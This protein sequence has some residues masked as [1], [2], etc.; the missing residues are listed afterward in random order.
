MK[1]SNPNTAVLG[2]IILISTVVALT[3]M[4]M[5]STIMM[6]RRR[7]I[8]ASTTPSHPLRTKKSVVVALHLAQLVSVYHRRIV[9]NFVFGDKMS[10]KI[11]LRVL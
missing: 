7:G 11:I 4:T 8:G 6:R 9:Y 1:N 10:I 3:Y 5:T 2:K